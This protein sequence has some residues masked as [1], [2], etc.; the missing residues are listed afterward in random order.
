MPL[1]RLLVASRGEIAILVW[2]RAVMARRSGVAAG[3]PACGA[4]EPAQN[5]E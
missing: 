2:S 1:H 3:G 4:L 5:I